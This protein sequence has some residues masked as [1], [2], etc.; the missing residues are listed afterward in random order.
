MV[1]SGAK[2]ELLKV[3]LGPGIRKES[4]VFELVNQKDDPEWKP[5][6]QLR[7]KG[8]ISIDLAGYILK[9]LKDSGVVSENITDTEIDTGSNP[10]YFSHF[11]AVKNDLKEGRFLSALR[12]I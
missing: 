2:P 8:L 3:I 9:Q 10:D 7:P 12:L 11:V 6:L 1:K 5:F 4:Y